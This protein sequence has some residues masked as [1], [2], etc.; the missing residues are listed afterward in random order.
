MRVRRLDDPVAFLSS[1]MPLLL[2]DEARHNLILGL[3]TTLR[4]HPSVYP[5]YK[6]WL[7]EEGSKP[8]CAALR[9]APHNLVL[10]RPQA[11][12]A[13]EALATAIDEELPGVVGGLPEVEEFGTLWAASA[14]VAERVVRRQG[15]YALERVKPVRGV[16]GGFRDATPD[17]R[18]R[19]IEW[20]HAF[21]A[22]VELTER[23][24][25]E[26]VGRMI[27]HRLSADGSGITIWEDDGPVSF[28]GYGGNT[29]NGVRIGPVYTPSAHRR[30]GYASAL[31]AELSARLLAGRR[32]CFLYTDLANPT[33]N[34]IYEQIGYER[35]CE[36]A[37]IVF[38]S[39][40]PE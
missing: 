37:E 23:R 18:P 40:A 9:T 29:P 6:I 22:E 30:H 3:A 8:V 12:D 11:G 38:E 7:V 16:P 32:F 24:D 1:A 35:V 17:D 21:A 10:A 25:E 13:L 33:S 36:S 19:L 26:S 2:A 31:V 27:D 5:D 15:I 14:G 39:V 20:F 4:D 28:A 34:K